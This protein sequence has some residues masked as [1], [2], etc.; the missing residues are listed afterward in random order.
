VDHVVFANYRRGAQWFL[1]AALGFPEGKLLFGDV[2]E[3]GHCFSADLLVTLD[4]RARDG[5][6]VP[7]RWLLANAMG[8]RTWSSIA[9]ECL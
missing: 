6:L 1:T 2:A 7:G 5:T 8:P 4:R 9:L 3:F